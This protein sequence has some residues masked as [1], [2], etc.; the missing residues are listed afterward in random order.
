MA[1][2]CLAI[3]RVL[4]INQDSTVKGSRR[5]DKGLLVWWTGCQEAG[6]QAERPQK[7][8]NHVGPPDA[9]QILLVRHAQSTGQGPEASLTEDGKDMS[10]A[11]CSFINQYF[12]VS[13]VLSSGYKRTLQ[14]IEGLSK[15]IVVV[16]ELAHRVHPN[17]SDEEIKERAIKFFQSIQQDG[18]CVVVTHGKVITAITGEAH[19]SSPDLFLYDTEEKK[20]TRLWT[21]EGRP[22]QPVQRP[23]S[24]AILLNSRKE[25]L[26]F[27][28]EL[29][30]TLWITPAGGVEPGETLESALERELY[31]ELG[32]T[33]D[34][35]SVKGHIW[36]SYKPKICSGLPHL[37]IDSY[38][39][40]QLIS[41]SISINQ[42]NQTEEERKVLRGPFWRS[43]CEL[44]TTTDL[45][46]PP[47]LRTF[48]INF[49]P[50]RPIVII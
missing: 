42:M 37:L 35:Y 40:V 26:L 10:T 38:F 25:V 5:E 31:E 3:V 47:Q 46:I 8:K 16:P 36:T 9:M 6:D 22:V 41:D 34:K 15:P 20:F 19:L 30:R 1:T 13:I 21:D 23:S 11:L 24:R 32:L 28:L 44:K 4:A 18:T 48:D 50:N 12:D 29:D 2:N 45:I 49:M 14:T 33:P 43:L 17:E 27:R 7:A 39:V